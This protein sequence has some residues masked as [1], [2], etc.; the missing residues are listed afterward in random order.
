VTGFTKSSL[1]TQ[2]LTHQTVNVQFISAKTSTKAD[3]SGFAW[4]PD[5]E[6]AHLAFPRIIRQYLDDPEARQIRMF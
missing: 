1:L 3:I 4:V 2:Q 5:K 6:L